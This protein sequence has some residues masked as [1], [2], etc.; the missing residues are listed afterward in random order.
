MSLTVGERITGLEIG[1]VAHGGHF[2]ARHDGRVLFIRGALTGE[3]V[4]VLVTEV[5]RRFAR[6]EVTAVREPSPHRVVAPC[7]VAG[8]CGG[9]D[10][11]HISAPHTRELKRQVVQELLG[12]LGGYEFAGD[13]EEVR[14]APLDWRTRMRYHVGPSGRPALLAHRSRDL[15]ELPEDGC[16]IAAREIARPDVSRVA[17]AGEQVIAALAGDEV[18]V[19]A[20]DRADQVLTEHVR[21]WSFSVAVDGFWQAHRG[22]PDTLVAAVMDGLRPRPGEVAADLYCGVGL[23]AGALVDS[24]CRVLGIEGDRRAT[25]LARR[26]VSRAHF[27]RGDVGLLVDRLPTVIDIAVL[28]PPRSGAGSLVLSSL[29]SRRPRAVAYVACDPAALGRDL[30]VAAELGYGAVSVRAFD[31]F[32][33][34]HHVECVAVLEPSVG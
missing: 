18:V 3:I 4:D 9:C 30:R 6:A 25:E 24:G 7:P 34:T 8:R 17:R 28:D 13:V 29:L 20:A 33:L 2:V 27:L 10:F 19:A 1:P 23:F 21:G 16:L 15:V 31:L 11:Q 32:P 5:N 22:A 12:H 14:P 26:N